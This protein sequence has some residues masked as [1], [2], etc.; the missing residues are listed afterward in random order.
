MFI[1][2]KGSGRQDAYI[3]KLYISTPNSVLF[4]FGVNMPMV[5]VKKTYGIVERTEESRRDRIV[6][7]HELQYH[8]DQLLLEVPCD[9]I[10]VHGDFAP[11]EI[12]VLKE[13]G[14]VNADRFTFIVSVHD[15]AVPAGHILIEEVE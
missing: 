5:S 8:F 7:Q 15:D 6:L 9:T 10:F 13:L 11:V 2:I 12:S 3:E 14:R 1:L 4:Q